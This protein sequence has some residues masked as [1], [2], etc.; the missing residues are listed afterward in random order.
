MLS[1]V[2]RLAER[3]TIEAARSSTTTTGVTSKATELTRQH[4]TALIRDRFTRETEQLNLRRVE[5][6]DVGGRR[7]QLFHQPSLLAA[8]QKAEVRQVLSEGEQTALGLAGLLTELAF[9]PSQSAIVLDDPV[10]SL[11]HVRRE[12]VARR[13]AEI[14]RERQVIVFTHDL[15][16]ISDIQNAAESVGVTV[17]ER[18]IER[19]G[20]NT[21]GIPVD[22]HPWKAKAVTSRLEALNQELQEIKQQ[23]PVWNQEE[24]EDHVARW[25]GRLSEAWERIIR[26]GIADSVVDT[27]TQH[28]KPLMTKLLARFTDADH[29]EYQDSY[30]RCSLWLTRHD[31][32]D[33]VNYVAPEPS[34]LEAELARVRAWWS[35]VRG[36]RG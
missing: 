16:F 27:G 11:D 29:R 25:A 12:H 5:L 24:Y 1:E 26:V 31:K 10:T 8:V 13:L 20:E 6:R 35:R 23:R 32:S 7:G 4:V 33:S 17:T 19:R 30:G 15:A 34:E 9:E 14:A 18:G 2:R 3:T 36:Y 28:V 21:P 22:H